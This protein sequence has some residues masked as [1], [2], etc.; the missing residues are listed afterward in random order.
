MTKDELARI[1]QNTNELRAFLR[2]E[3]RLKEAYANSQD[4]FPRRWQPHGHS[5]GVSLD[6]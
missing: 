5:R 1:Q 2:Y 6:R 3:Q 4:P